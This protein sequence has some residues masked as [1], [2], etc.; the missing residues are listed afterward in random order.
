[1]FDRINSTIARHADIMLA[2]GVV[3]MIATMIVRLPPQ[4]MDFLLAA[5]IM[6]AMTLLTASL[7]ARDA[8]RFPSFPTILLLTTLFRLAL[9]VST[10]RLILLDGNAGEIITA[11]GDFVVRGNYVVGAVIFLIL[12][13]IQFIVIAKGSERV[14][15][16]S[17]RFTL[18]A[19]QGKQMS[20]DADLRAQLITPEDARRRRSALDKES[21]LFGA[22][23]GAMKFVKGDALAGIIISVINIA[24][25]L[26]VGVLQQGMPIGEAAQLYSL[27]TI[28][29][30][31]VSQI[32][33]LLICVSAGLVVT[34]VAGEDDASGHDHLA[35]D[36]FGQILGNRRVVAI[37]AGFAALLAISG[38]ITG[39]PTVPFAI[40]STAL[41]IPAIRTT[42]PKTATESAGRRPARST[43]SSD[44]VASD[45]PSADP[46]R[47][48]LVEQPRLWLQLGR[49]AHA[50]IAQTSL[51]EHAAHLAR[52]FTIRYGVPLPLPVIQA[53]RGL[54]DD[55]FV[56]RV[57]GVIADAGRLPAEGLLVALIDPAL[58]REKFDI[59]PDVYA[60]SSASQP[61]ASILP[62]TSGGPIREAGFPLLKPE[63]MLLQQIRRCIT[64]RLPDLYRLQDLGDQIEFLQRSNRQLVTAVTPTLLTLA[65]IWEVL[66][67]LLDDELP[68]TDLP[69]ILESLAKVTP[70]PTVRASSDRATFVRQLIEAVRTDLADVVCETYRT[71]PGELSY[72]TLDRE[73]IEFVSEAARNGG[74]LAMP[75][76]TEQMILDNVDQQLAILEA[77]GIPSAPAIVVPG[78]LRV[79][80][81]RLVRD[82]FPNVPVMRFEELSPDVRQRHCGEIRLLLG[83]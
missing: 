46:A 52:E 10:T 31:L 50:R 47:Q 55:Q 65:E 51:P 30:G 38:G 63:Q 79:P 75:R 18:D 68:I 39:L 43:P 80:V 27:L 24:G 41:L 83:V 69:R 26:I 60:T 9:N 49:S 2:V 71:G 22:M 64:R 23:D 17:A 7:Y 1:M 33:A 57:N 15:E 81:R 34:R 29:D 61:N 21:K 25:G 67:G 73:I 16:V 45:A 76:E 5:N 44:S 19:M 4:A 70:P 36:L 82:R 28:G 32:P 8:A 66:I 72:L 11:F 13:L 12:V 20:I 48:L 3:A 42:T 59:E 58:C 37:S 54:P 6:L 77:S 78:P 14:A 40:L 62:A 56:F 74:V 53:S 35:R